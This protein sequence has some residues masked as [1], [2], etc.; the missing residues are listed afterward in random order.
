MSGIEV[1]SYFDPEPGHKEVERVIY[2]R[3]LDHIFFVYRSPENG[4]LADAEATQEPLKEG[5]STTSAIPSTADTATTNEGNDNNPS[6]S[7][8]KNLT[9][10]MGGSGAP[11]ATTGNPSSNA[12]G[13][14]TPNLASLTDAL[15]EPTSALVDTELELEF[16]KRMIREEEP[17]PHH[18]PYFIYT[19]HLQTARQII[20]P[21]CPRYTKS[22]P[23]SRSVRQHNAGFYAAP[24]KSQGSCNFI[25][26]SEIFYLSQGNIE[27][28]ATPFNTYSLAKE[29]AKH[30][31]QGPIWSNRL[32]YSDHNNAFIVFFEEHTQEP[33]TS[34]ILPG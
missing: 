13:S 11:V 16:Q 31:A 14:G 28:Y 32:L 23:R 30:S 3:T 4:S 19:L 21:V 20:P 10:P 2:H 7:T 6:S 1:P 34:N 15:T 24:D 17:F 8:G 9:T 33:G 27:A 29:V 25:F 22:T 12:S 5:S 26:N 18:S